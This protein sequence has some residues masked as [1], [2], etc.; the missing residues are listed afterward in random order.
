L[1]SLSNQ[2]AGLSVGICPQELEELTEIYVQRGLPHDL[3]RAVAVELSKKDVVKA[4][5]RE[6][7]GVHH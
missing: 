6:E 5:A 3:A 1:A 7:L 4:H 2:G